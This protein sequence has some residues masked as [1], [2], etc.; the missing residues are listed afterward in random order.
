MSYS[1]GGTIQANDYNN[2]AWGGN[3]TGTYSGTIK[4]LAIVMGTGI[5][6]TKEVMVRLSQQ[7]T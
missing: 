3:T 2:L 6:I 4:N 5:G 7:L 1:S